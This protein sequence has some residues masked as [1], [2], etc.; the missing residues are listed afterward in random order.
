MRYIFLFPF[1][2]YRIES[3]KK[4]RIIFLLDTQLYSMLALMH[5]QRSY[6]PGWAGQDCPSTGLS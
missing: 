2:I 1:T 3:C 6:M 4:L 5:E